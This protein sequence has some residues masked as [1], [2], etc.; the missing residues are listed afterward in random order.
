M[1]RGVEAFCPAS[2]NCPKDQRTELILKLVSVT[3]HER[4][5]RYRSRSPISLRLRALSEKGNTSFVERDLKTSRL[6]RDLSNKNTDKM[7]GSPSKFTTAKFG[8]N[9]ASTD[10]ANAGP[11]GQPKQSMLHT[12][13]KIDPRL[14]QRF[15]E[16]SGPTKFAPEPSL[17]STENV[18]FA[19]VF[20]SVI[21]PAMRKSKK[22]HKNSLPWEDLDAIGQTVSILVSIL[23]WRKLSLDERALTF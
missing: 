19:A 20:E 5:Q 2:V 4:A 14:Q 11:F 13:E 22:R 21:Y 9:G 16:E 18:A 10:R 12:Q 17:A 7:N 23:I 1:E 3:F 8:T 6:E 15:H